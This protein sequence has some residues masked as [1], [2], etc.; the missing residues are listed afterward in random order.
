MEMEER[1]PQEKE[2]R[3]PEWLEHLGKAWEAFLRDM[4]SVLPEETREHL[5]A[6][7][8][9]RLLAMRSLIDHQIERL[10]KKPTRTARKVEIE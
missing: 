8:R 6:S 3:P 2:G 4:K 10:E 1:T 9:E 7:R 5:R